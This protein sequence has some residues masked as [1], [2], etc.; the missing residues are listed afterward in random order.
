MT[1]DGWVLLLCLSFGARMVDL[2]S[3][4]RDVQAA[5]S[6]PVCFSVHGDG[7]SVCILLAHLRLT[8][9]LNLYLSRLSP[10]LHTPVQ[11]QEESAYRELVTPLEQRRQKFI[12]RRHEHGDRSGE[13]VSS[14][15]GFMLLACVVAVGP[16]QLLLV[17]RK[18]AAALI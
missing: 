9:V 16:F 6:Q 15:T 4:L 2:I 1:C 10:F 3:R 11:Y 8:S 13:V 17:W 12:K 7:W 5:P 14:G 18:G